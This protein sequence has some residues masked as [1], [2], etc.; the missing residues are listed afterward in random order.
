MCDQQRLRPACAYAQSDQSLF[1]SLEYST[2]MSVKL[3]TEHV[4][5]FLSLKGG[6][7]GKSE[8]TF[9]KI[10]HCWKSHVAAL[11]FDG[12]TGLGVSYDGHLQQQASGTQDSFNQGSSQQVNLGL[13]SNFICFP[14]PD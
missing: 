14:L 4:L 3:L 11:I 13:N 2:G 12:F 10:P 9:V 5:E 8:S 6:R 1:W 7:R